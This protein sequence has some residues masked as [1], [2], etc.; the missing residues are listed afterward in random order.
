MSFRCLYLM[1]YFI[2]KRHQTK[3][4]VARYFSLGLQQKEILLFLRVLHKEN[5]SLRTLKRILSH[6]NL[7][8]RKDFSR[9]DDVVRFIEGELNKSG[10]LHGYKW[11]HLRCLQNN[12]VV[13]QK[14]VRELLSLLDPEGVSLRQKRRLRRRQY[15][16][17]GPN[18]LWH[19]DSYDKLKPYGI[20]INGCIDGFSRHIIWLRAGITASNPKVRN[21]F[22]FSKSID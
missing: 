3:D 1:I 18:Y 17:K 8:R 7:Y 9:I 20:C 14:V 13:T 6:L 21:S 11:M 4:L 5:M 16:N 12:L 22:E 10:Q 19:V 15:Q 2:F